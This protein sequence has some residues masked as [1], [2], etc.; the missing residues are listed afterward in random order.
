MQR[1]LIYMLTLRKERDGLLQIYE[2]LKEDGV[3][4]ECNRR[5]LACFL[6]TAIDPICLIHYNWWPGTGSYNRQ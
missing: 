5:D 4:T 2:T 3:Q 1:S 6:S